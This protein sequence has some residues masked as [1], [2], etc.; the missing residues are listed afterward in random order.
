MKK[1][2]QDLE[3][4]DKVIFFSFTI[5]KRIKDFVEFRRNALFSSAATSFIN[6]VSP[7]RC[8]LLTIEK[9]KTQEKFSK[10]I[11]FSKTK[12]YLIKPC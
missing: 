12:E 3:R 11:V 7:K 10:T 4:H 8:V 6:T 1:L 5:F 2:S 9:F